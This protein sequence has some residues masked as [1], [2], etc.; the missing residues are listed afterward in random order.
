MLFYIHK[1]FSDNYIIFM[2]FLILK[3]V[4]YFNS[5]IFIFFIHKSKD[6]NKYDSL[7]LN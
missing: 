2:L 7:I 1:L 6:N 3:M 4:N 5:Y